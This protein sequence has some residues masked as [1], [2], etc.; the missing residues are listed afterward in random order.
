[1][2]Q[3]DKRE[4]H[5]AE[6]NRNMS[7]NDANSFLLAESYVVSIWDSSASID[8][9]LSV[10]W[11]TVVQVCAWPRAHILKFSRVGAL[12]EKRLE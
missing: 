4:K 7:H 5:S 8:T 3:Q 10:Q 12:P 2:D 11:S 1:V 6:P 9:F